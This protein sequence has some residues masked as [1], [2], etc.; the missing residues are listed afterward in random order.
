MMLIMV[1]EAY[2]VRMDVPDD[3]WVLDAT[4][5]HDAVQSTLL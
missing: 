4:E 3:D 5:D 1:K 2:L